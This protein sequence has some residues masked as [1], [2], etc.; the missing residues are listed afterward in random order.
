MVWKNWVRIF[1]LLGQ[2]FWWKFR[3][4][5]FF[6]IWLGTLQYRHPITIIDL[7]NFSVNFEKRLGGGGVIPRIAQFTTINNIWEDIFLKLSKTNCDP[8]ISGFL[9]FRA[10]NLSFFYC[11]SESQ[12]LGFL[13]TVY[14][15]CETSI[16]GRDKH[17]RSKRHGLLYMYIQ[18]LMY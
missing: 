6:L 8:C 14:T 4:G 13:E 10:K 12:V 11:L 1:C 9:A 16:H 18:N 7:L 17:S 15:V 2:E 5:I 3:S